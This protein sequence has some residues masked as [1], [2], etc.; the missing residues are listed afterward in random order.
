M[1][2][3]ELTHPLIIKKRGVYIQVPDN[4]LNALTWVINLLN[5][6]KTEIQAKEEAE[7]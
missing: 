3:E 6:V 7:K 4:D 1:S 5:Y 2:P